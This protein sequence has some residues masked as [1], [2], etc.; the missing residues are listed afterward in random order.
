MGRNP[1]Q[2]ANSGHFDLTFSFVEEKGA[3]QSLQCQSF[4]DFLAVQL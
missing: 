2:I 4:M 3:D 1:K